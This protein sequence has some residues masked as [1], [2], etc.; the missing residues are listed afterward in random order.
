MINLEIFSGI[1]EIA[2]YEFALL[3][4]AETAALS[5]GSTY[6]DIFK[7]W[8]VL[9]LNGLKP[10][11]SPETPMPAFFPADERLVGFDHPGSNWGSAWNSFLSVCGKAEDRKRWASD[12]E[13]YRSFI[14]EFFNLTG[15]KLPLFDLVFLGIGPD[16]H[17]A[18]LFP[19]NC[20]AEHD[21]DWFELVLKTVSPF[22]PKD[23]LSLG[24][25]VISQS[26]KLV[27]TVTGT[28]KAGIFNRLLTEINSRGKDPKEE[29]LPPARIIR[30]R[31]SL[32]LDTLIIC[33]RQAKQTAEKEEGV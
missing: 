13:I 24:P 22:N 29:F 19:A 1:E 20:P 33:D 23:R 2:D 4:K 28:S 30:N 16:G 7:R 17:T 14:N 6:E 31:E 3:A 5:F 8:K 12:A 21:A 9:Y 18:S 25:A 11:I 10:G 26:K 27:L 32:G 15:S